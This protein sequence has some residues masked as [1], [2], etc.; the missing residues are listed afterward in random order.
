MKYHFL[1]APCALLL[2]TGCG[3]K[4]AEQTPTAP[5]TAEKAAPEN[6]TLNAVA[7]PIVTPTTAASTATPVAQTAPVTPRDSLRVR[8]QIVQLPTENG[9][10]VIVVNHENIPGL[11]PAM[12]MRLPLAAPAE[13]RKLAPGDKIAFDLDRQNMRVSNIEKLPPST[14]LQL[15]P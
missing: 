5:L 13:A 4:P 11:M 15:A 14:P 3:G 6:G 10:S 7:T 9:G 8:G 12:Q 1:I 2:L